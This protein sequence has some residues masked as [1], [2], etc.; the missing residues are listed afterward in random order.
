MCLLL[1]FSLTCCAGCL[2][3]VKDKTFEQ[4]CEHDELD[5]VRS[6]HPTVDHHHAIRHYLDNIL[7]YFGSR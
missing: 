6:L 7:G 1:S 5:V 3:I 2:I 4:Q